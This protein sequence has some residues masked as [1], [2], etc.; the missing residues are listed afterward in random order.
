M[1]YRV[2]FRVGVLLKP[3]ACSELVYVLQSRRRLFVR[4]RQMHGVLLVQLL[5]S[6][7]QRLGSGFFDCGYYSG[8]LPYSF[9]VD[10]C[11]LLRM[12]CDGAGEEE[13]E[14]EEGGGGGRHERWRVVEEAGR[15][16]PF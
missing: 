13:E 16:A 7:G 5:L 6:F 1:V 4:N 9:G 3:L 10:F 12:R 8:L 2:R 14:E 11:L 15:G